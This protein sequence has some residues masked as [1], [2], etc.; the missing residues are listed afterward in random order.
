MKKEPEKKEPVL[1]DVDIQKHTDPDFVKKELEKLSSN[2]E[3]NVQRLRNLGM[4]MI[5]GST[6]QE[7]YEKVFN[8]K[9]DYQKRTIPNLNKGPYDVW[10]WVETKPAEVPERLKNH[11]ASIKLSVSLYLTD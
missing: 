3:I 4:V 2:L 9:L 8:A 1:F 10:E 11:I 5:N 7:T 6:D